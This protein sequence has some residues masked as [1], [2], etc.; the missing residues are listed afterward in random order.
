MMSDMD[1][2]YLPDRQKQQ[3]RDKA[4]RQRRHQLDEESSRSRDRSPIRGPKHA[5]SRQSSDMS[6]QDEDIETIFLDDL[7]YGESISKDEYDSFIPILDQYTDDLTSTEQVEEAIEVIASSYF[8]VLLDPEQVQD[9]AQLYYHVVG[10]RL[11]HIYKLLIPESQNIDMAFRAINEL[12]YSEMPGVNL[13]QNFAYQY[14]QYQ[15]GTSFSIN[16]AWN[17][18][19]PAGGSE[20]RIRETSGTDSINDTKIKFYSAKDFKYK[21]AT[22]GD[23][24]INTIVGD[25]VEA[26]LSRLAPRGESAEVNADQSDLM[27]NVLVYNNNGN[28]ANEKGWIRGHLLND[29]LGGSA[30]KFNLYPIT[31]SAN[32]EHHSRVESHVKNLVEAGYIVEYKVEVVPTVPAPHQKETAP[33]YKSGAAPKANFVCSVKVLSDTSTDAASSYHPEGSFSVT[34][35]SEYK[36]KHASTGDVATLKAFANKAVKSKDNKVDSKAYMRPWTTKKGLTKPLGLSQSD[37]KHIRDKDYKDWTDKQKNSKFWTWDQ[38]RIDALK[39][40]LKG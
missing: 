28:N 24:T 20:E 5:I 29:N 19:I 10:A 18:T 21:N 31:G 22:G 3:Q 37:D 15:V 39:A 23:V 27:K 7:D 11:S 13:I 40:A 17:I 38:T 16:P 9:V 34:I 25:K 14:N 12:A 2:S 6:V 36:T 30:L 32:K 33:G 8:D 35:T 4:F 26:R 1:S